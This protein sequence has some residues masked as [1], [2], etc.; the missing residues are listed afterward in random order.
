M[1]DYEN[2]PEQIVIAVNANSQFIS[3]SMNKYEEY[4][5]EQVNSYL[6]KGYTVKY[7]NA[8]PA[9]NNSTYYSLVFTLEKT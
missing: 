1:Q 4:E 2:L 6:R 7:V 9:S 3:G 8:F 5:F